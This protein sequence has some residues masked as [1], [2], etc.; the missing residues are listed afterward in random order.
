MAEGFQTA[1][2]SYY[3]SIKNSTVEPRYMI[4][5]IVCA[6]AES[7]KVFYEKNILHRKAAPRP[8]ESLLRPGLP[9]TTKQIFRALP[10]HPTTT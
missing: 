8:S 4:N 2:L 9:R 3:D 5:L 7:G 10:R 1:G 6:K